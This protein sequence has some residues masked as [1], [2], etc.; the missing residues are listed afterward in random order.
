MQDLKIYGL[1]VVAMLFSAVSEINPILQ[2]LVLMLSL[3]YTAIGIYK[4][5][6]K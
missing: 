5:L 4:Q 6:N 1:S 3:V 2:T